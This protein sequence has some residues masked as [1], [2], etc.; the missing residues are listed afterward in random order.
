MI[1]TAPRKG[2]LV[3]RLRGT[4]ARKPIL[5]MA[6]IDVVEAKR[7]D[8]DFDPFKLQEADGYFHGRG[9]ID[10]KAMA[11]IFV[12]NL[13]EY[14]QEGFRPERDIILALTTDEELSDSPHDGV[15]VAARAPSRPDRRRARHQRRRRRRAARR[16]AVPHCACSS[17]K[18]SIRPTGWK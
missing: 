18:R 11:S 14:A 5:L 1:S 13:I 17:P 3:A 15:H 8:W 7:E 10:D 9:A 16:Q 2:N 6:H 12:A 4:G